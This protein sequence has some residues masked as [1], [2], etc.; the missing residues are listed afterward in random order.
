VG[1]REL[2]T[3][4]AG[5]FA[6]LTLVRDPADVVSNVAAGIAGERVWRIP[7]LGSEYGGP[8]FQLFIE[9]ATERDVGLT[10][11]CGATSTPSTSGD[12]G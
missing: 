2:P 5:F 7:A 4:V 10:V 3:V 12:G 9:R 11:R 1:G 8:G 6:D